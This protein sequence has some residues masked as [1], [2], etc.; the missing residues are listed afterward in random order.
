MVHTLAWWLLRADAEGEGLISPGFRALLPGRLLVELG[1]S[2]FI[3]RTADT[4]AWWASEQRRRGRLRSAAGRAQLSAGA[5]AGLEEGRAGLRGQ[6]NG[7]RGSR[8]GTVEVNPTA[9]HK[10]AGSLAGLAQWV[11]DPLLP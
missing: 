1:T 9:V 5:E 11:K 6:E 3:V 10:D 7:P 4:A 8:C 2:V